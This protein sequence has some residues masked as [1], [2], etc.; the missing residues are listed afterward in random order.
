MGT[1]I[2]SDADD[3]VTV[4]V[5]LVYPER[6][7]ST[8]VVADAPAERPVTVSGRVEPATVPALTDPALTDGDHVKL[9][10]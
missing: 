7:V 5:P 4:A 1:G 10:S 3:P 2:G 6:E 8:V 9:A